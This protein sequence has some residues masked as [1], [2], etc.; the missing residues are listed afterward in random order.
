MS[1]WHELDSR[2]F[3]Q[4]FSAAGLFQESRRKREWKRHVAYNLSHADLSA[5]CMSNRNF[6]FPGFFLQA[7]RN[8][9]IAIYHDNR[10]FALSDL[11]FQSF[12]I[13]YKIIA[14]NPFQD[15]RTL[16]LFLCISVFVGCCFRIRLCLSAFWWFRLSI[17]TAPPH[18]QTR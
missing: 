10:T 16:R 14:K 7:F 2:F 6:L 9:Q 17:A 15:V 5:M 8:L 3:I 1:W 11:F 12:R 18:S 4:F 13:T